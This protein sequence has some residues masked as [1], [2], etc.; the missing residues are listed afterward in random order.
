MSRIWC[1]VFANR[2]ITSQCPYRKKG[3]PFAWQMD[4]SDYNNVIDM[5]CLERDPT[6]VIPNRRVATLCVEAIEALHRVAPHKGTSTANLEPPINPNPIPLAPLSNSTLSDFEFFPNTRKAERMPTD[7]VY[8][9]RASRNSQSY[10]EAVTRKAKTSKPIEK[11]A[12]VKA[13]DMDVRSSGTGSPVSFGVEQEATAIII[14]D[15]RSARP[16]GHLIPRIE[17]DLPR[18]RSTPNRIAGDG[19]KTAPI[20][21]DSDSVT[22]QEVY[23]DRN[24]GN[25]ENDLREEVG[26]EEGT[27]DEDDGGWESTPSAEDRENSITDVRDITPGYLLMSI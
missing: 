5:L 2:L 14:R 22:E 7:R 9:G 16:I 15:N 10:E 21:L 26:G 18:R 4:T 8:G 1:P 24:R 13:D 25:V 27:D 12:A 6:F 23:D 20:E 17:V 19:S 3:H 11:M